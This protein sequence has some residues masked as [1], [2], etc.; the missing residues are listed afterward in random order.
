MTWLALVLL[1]ALVL[2]PLLLIALRASGRRAEAQGRGELAMSLHRAQLQEL[3]RDR[4]DGR[5]DATEHATATLEVQRRLLAAADQPEVAAARDRRGPLVATLALV[6]L[7]G[8]GLYVL[9]DGRPTLPAQPLAA[10]LERASRDDLVN[11][12]LIAVLRQ[13]LAAM[14]Q[15]S[16]LARQ[17]YVLLGNVEDGRGHLAAAAEAWRKA[18]AIQFDPGLAA[19]AAEAQTR[20]DAGRLGP[21]SRAL[22]TRA[23]AEAPADA[24]WRAVAQ[25]RLAGQPVAP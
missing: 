1:A 12:Q 10:R 22:F 14:D 16:P 4:T 2:A 9:S 13:K 15:A 11:D 18:V 20:V 3:D 23:L 19:L 25:Q 24:P 8:V 21:E 17:G 5:I 7:L 6:P